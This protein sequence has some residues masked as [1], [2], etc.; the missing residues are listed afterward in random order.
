MSQ[1][2]TV[3]VSDLGPGRSVYS[4]DYF[5]IEGRPA[6]PIRWMA[7]ESMLLVRTLAPSLLSL[8][9]PALAYIPF[10]PHFHFLFLYVRPPLVTP[11]LTVLLFFR[12]GWFFIFYWETIYSYYIALH[13]LRNIW[14]FHVRGSAGLRWL[15]I[16]VRLLVTWSAVYA[17][18][19]LV[20][21]C[22]ISKRTKVWILQ[23]WLYLYS[24]KAYFPVFSLCS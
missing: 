20:A 11:L 1:G 13:I 3:K 8:V 16:E 6:L 4:A 17:L 15:K 12:V 14:V 21:E 19:P 9:N 5:K 7:W 10:N 22:D 18:L 24:I 2:Y 23:T